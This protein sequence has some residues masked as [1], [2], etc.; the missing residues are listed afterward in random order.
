MWC[1]QIVLFLFSCII[2]VHYEVMSDRLL[3]FKELIKSNEITSEWVDENTS[4]VHIKN[5]YYEIYIYKPKNDLTSEQRHDS[6]L[7]EFYTCINCE[8]G[9]WTQHQLLIFVKHFPVFYNSKFISLYNNIF[10]K[11]IKTFVIHLDSILKITT[12]FINILSSFMNINKYEPSIDTI[13]LKSMILLNLK[14]NYIK[15]LSNNDNGVDDFDIKV[16]TDDVIILFMLEIINSIQY[17]MTVNCDFSSQYEKRRFF[18]YAPNYSELNKK[19]ITEFL[20]DIESTKLESS[21]SCNVKQML[22]LNK[23]PI[24]IDNV[25]WNTPYGK[26]LVIDVVERIKKLHDLEIIFWYQ[27]LMLK[28]IMKILFGETHKYFQIH[29]K[30]SESILNDFEII[31]SMVLLDIINLPIDGLIQCFTLLLS[32]RDRIYT[33]NDP[34]VLTIVKYLE[35]LDEIDLGTDLISDIII[36]DLNDDNRLSN[37]TN[38]EKYIDRIILIVEDF[39]C[40]FRLNEFLQNEHNNSYYT[41]YTKSFVK[42]KRFVKNILIDSISSRNLNP[43]VE[44]EKIRMNLKNDLSD[45]INIMIDDGCNYIGTLYNLCFETFVVIN[46]A[47]AECQENKILKYLGEA[48][49]L[50]ENIWKFLMDFFNTFHWERSIFKIVYTVTPLIESIMYRFDQIFRNEYF[51][52]LIRLISVVMNVFNEYA[53]EF[54]SNLSK[55]NYLFFNNINF[56]E[57]GKPMFHFEKNIKKSLINFKSGFFKRN[58]SHIFIKLKGLYE[59]HYKFFFINLSMYNKIIKLK[60]KGEIYNIEDIYKYI[61]SAVLN[62]SYYYA[63]NDFYLK[64]Y[65]AAVYYEI[66]QIKNVTSSKKNCKIFFKEIHSILIEFSFPKYFDNI[67]VSFNKY[68]NILKYNFCFDKG[69]NNNIEEQEV[70]NKIHN[71]LKE[72]GVYIEDELSVLYNVDESKSSEITVDEPSVLYNV[73]E[74][75]SSE[76]TVDHETLETPSSNVYFNRCI[77]ALVKIFKAVKNIYDN[78]EYMISIRR[79]R[80]DDIR[81]KHKLLEK[82]EKQAFS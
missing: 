39:K 49:Y 23:I 15:S 79:S 37:K 38:L 58:A 17:Y 2:T 13:V 45:E 62:P 34:L 36:S 68:L 78:L 50:C 66:I 77:N 10:A 52:D 67:I 24:K 32:N 76:I 80:Q 11:N 6:T 48:K 71:Q 7:N 20:G 19:D 35:S 22:L 70:R 42:I 16:L 12:R 9:A 8:F 47:F 18:G 27:K 56:T 5:K 69:N 55:Y 43:N 81:L 29:K 74:S 28:T 57:V 40:F 63:I 51:K 33:E 72:I 31:Y 21:K 61:M 75:E 53:I 82:F 44:M 26:V 73:D 3:D 59:I 4:N 65:I 64:Y 14:I 41:P 46:K 1:E 25:K 54:C 60:W 30:F